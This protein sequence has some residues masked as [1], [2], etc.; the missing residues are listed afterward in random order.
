MR[1]LV[2]QPLQEVRRRGPVGIL[3]G[4]VRGSAG[5]VLKPMVGL[6]DFVSESTNGLKNSTQRAFGLRAELNKQ[7]GLLGAA[8]RSWRRCRA[9]GRRVRAASC[10]ASSRTT[11]STRP[12][13][14]CCGWRTI[15]A[16]RSRCGW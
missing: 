11:W 7:V 15:P 10:R 16:G 12:G 1:G 9:C 8:Q 3:S 5:L 14:C 2:T 4:P 13:S 6:L